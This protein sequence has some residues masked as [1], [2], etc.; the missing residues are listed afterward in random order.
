MS[1]D[2][3]DP[4]GEVVWPAWV[5]WVIGIA[6]GII[7]IGGSILLSD[8]PEHL[9]YVVMLVRGL[10]LSVSSFAV[11][12]ASTQRDARRRSRAGRRANTSANNLRN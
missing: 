10:G 7:S 12:V 8:L 6:G 5:L 2:E 4:D 1:S 3:E 9:D 11:Y